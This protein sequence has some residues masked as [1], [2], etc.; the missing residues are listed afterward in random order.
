MLMRSWYINLTR[1]DTTQGIQGLIEGVGVRQYQ[2]LLIVFCTRTS[3]TKPA[4]LLSIPAPEFAGLL[5]EWRRTTRFQGQQGL[6]KCRMDGGSWGRERSYPIVP[7]PGVAPTMI[8]V[9]MWG[10]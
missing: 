8:R 3:N 5:S 9:R 4:I 1:F 10:D 7:L 6:S 2:G